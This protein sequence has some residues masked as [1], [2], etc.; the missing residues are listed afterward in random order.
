MAAR[1]AAQ[2][3]LAPL[4]HRGEVPLVARLG[5]CP[6]MHP[7]DTGGVLWP[8][9]SHGD[10][11]AVGQVLAPAEPVLLTPR[12]RQRRHQLEQGR[13]PVL[14]GAREGGLHPPQDHVALQRPLQPQDE[15]GVVG[16]LRG[17]GHLPR[18]GQHE[19]GCRLGGPVGIRGQAGRELEHAGGDV[20]RVVVDAPR[21]DDIGSDRRDSVH[22]RRPVDLERRLEDEVDQLL[23]LGHGGG[24]QAHDVDPEQGQHAQQPCHRRGHGVDGDPRA[25]GVDRIGAVGGVVGGQGLEQPC[26][27][28]GPRPG[29]AP[30]RGERRQHR[31]A[32]PHGDQVKCRCVVVEGLSGQALLRIAG[33]GP[34]QLLDHR[35]H[36]VPPLVEPIDHDV[37]GA[38]VVAGSHQRLQLQGV[39]RG[40]RVAQHLARGPQQGLEGGFHRVVGLGPHV[41]GDGRERQPPHHL[42]QQVDPMAPDGRDG[43]Q[44]HVGLAGDVTASGIDDAALGVDLGCSVQHA[45]ALLRIDGHDDTL[46]VSGR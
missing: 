2:V 10:R 28:G 23:V 26:R 36:G 14:L 24:E 8:A 44:R 34:P 9:Q 39:P 31:Q 21:D 3:L 40:S 35:Q 25:P 33:P 5:G 17:R 42:A 12:L 43:A 13:G 37:L 45:I 18:V 27:E 7:L 11:K 29:V 6:L 20:G 1:D 19:V 4:V 16:A 30:A 32:E 15:R 38:L 22:E 46:A 41:L